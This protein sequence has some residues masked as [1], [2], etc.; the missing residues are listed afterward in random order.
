MSRIKYLSITQR[1][2]GKPIIYSGKTDRSGS[3]VRLP[4]PGN[5]IEE[6]TK[7][8]WELV[9]T[10]PLPEMKKSDF[11]D[12]WNEHKDLESPPSPIPEAMAVMDVIEDG[13]TES[14]TQ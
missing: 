7:I 13:E 1:E 6:M 8:E 5:D 9:A 12:W 10:F 11:A 2:G 3:L 14:D 4:K